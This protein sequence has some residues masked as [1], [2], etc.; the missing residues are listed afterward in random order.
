[1]TQLKEG[2]K[3]PQFKGKNQNGYGL[4]VWL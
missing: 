1:M 3:A 4:L 2:M